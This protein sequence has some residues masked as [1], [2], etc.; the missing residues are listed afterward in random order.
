MKKL[1]EQILAFGVVG[2]LATLIDY[3]LMILLTEVFHVFYLLS[4]TLSF[5]VSLVFNYICSMKFVFQSRDD[6]SRRKE[7]FIFLVLSI[8][9]LLINQAVLWLM[10][11]LF[12]VWYAIA[13]IFATGIVM[14]WNFITRKLCLE[15]KN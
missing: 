3:F 5:L 4:S 15:K 6:L 9:G 12:H 10:V 14:I 7:F 8:L 1:M 13:K 11:E 2:I